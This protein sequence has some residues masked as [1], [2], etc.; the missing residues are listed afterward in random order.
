MIVTEIASTVKNPVFIPNIRN[1]NEATSLGLPDWI[2]VDNS[3]FS[4][5]AKRGTLRI[6]FV[7]NKTKRETETVLT[8]FCSRGNRISM[9]LPSITP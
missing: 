6:A 5:D 3:I 9:A 1:S 2:T 8:W 4:G 7:K